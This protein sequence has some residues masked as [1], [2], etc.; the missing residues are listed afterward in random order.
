M[1]LIQDFKLSKTVYS[2]CFPETELAFKNFISNNNF[3]NLYTQTWTKKQD[4]YHIEF[5]NS[6]KEWS[7]NSIKF[8]LK[9][10][11]PTNG[12][13]EA[14]R[15]QIAYISNSKNIFVFEGEYEGYEAIVEGLGKK[16]TKIKRSEYDK[17]ENI[18]LYN[19]ST[20]FFISQPSSIDGN[21]WEGFQ[22]F[23]KIMESKNSSVFVDIVYIGCTK[24]DIQLDL[25]SESIK[26]LFFSLSKSFGVYYHRIGG[27]YLKDENPLLY[28]NIWFKNILSMKFGVKL[29]NEFKLGYF[30]KKYSVEKEKVISGIERELNIKVI[31]SSSLLL[32][33]VQK[34][35]LSFEK[36][37]IRDS[38]SKQL[39]VCITPRLENL[40]KG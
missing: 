27:C 17:K 29:M 22:N 7:K 20:A 1:N 2:L 18:E 8:N 16:V 6:F 4:E 30:P 28:G 25:T 40:I 19:S 10:F 35:G 13:S 39:R 32:V 34:T 23:I 15:E 9:H 31:D 38:A 11:Y 5:E 37:L 36:Y 12:A 21:Y 26:G 33:N 3:S 14:I 24:E